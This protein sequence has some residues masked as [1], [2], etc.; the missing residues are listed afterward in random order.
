MKQKL[1][2]T[3]K[4]EFA[5]EAFAKIHGRNWKSV[6]RDAWMSGAYPYGSDTASLQQVRNY[7]GPAWLVSYRL[8]KEAHPRPKTDAW[9]CP[10]CGKIYPT[11]SGAKCNWKSVL[12][13]AWI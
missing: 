4:Q 8:P 13:D 12:R 7:F 6:L 10:A 2:L 1:T 3:Q 5:I 11:Y 9:S